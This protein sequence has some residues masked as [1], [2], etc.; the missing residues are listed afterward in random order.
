M[1]DICN[2]IPPKNGHGGIEYFHFVYETEIKKFKQPLIRGNYY[3]NLV[4][5]GSGTVKISG[6]EEKLSPG[7]L[8]FTFPSTPFTI[9]CDDD[10]TFLYISFNGEGSSAL[11]ESFDISH[12]N[13]V[14]HNLENLTDFWMK[15]VRRINHLNANVLTES[16]LM[17]SLSFLPGSHS[18][19]SQSVSRF[20]SVMEYLNTNYTDADLSVMK[21]ADMFFYSKKY[22]SAL[23][24][25]ETGVKFTDYLNSLRI[26]HAKE[27]IKGGETSVS[28]ISAGC[29]FSDSYY[30]SKVFKKHTE[31][32]PTQ[33]IKSV[34]KK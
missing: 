33:Y 27:M 15:A 32:T 19:A 12:E 7:T 23:F 5:K 4:F 9:E 20:E 3:I 25:K 17:Y 26:T 30:F 31:M 28:L 11:L 16:V 14:F 21:V 8:F 13:C 29:G 2:F 22:L 34:S 1:K 10:F 24:I 6:C 18:N